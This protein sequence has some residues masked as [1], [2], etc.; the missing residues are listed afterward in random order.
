MNYPKDLQQ[1]WL[2][3]I[4]DLITGRHE[5]LGYRLLGTG[6]LDELI[7]LVYRVL[8]GDWSR[9]DWRYGI[10]VRY[11]YQS[12]VK[13]GPYYDTPPGLKQGRV[14]GIL[15]GEAYGFSDRDG[16]LVIHLDGGPV[17]LSPADSWTTASQTKLDKKD[18]E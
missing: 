17:I 1:H 8:R 4:G 7:D 10:R 14:I 12:D 3:R 16:V 5:K 15:P 6:L 13:H 18:F 11:K 2:N 9:L